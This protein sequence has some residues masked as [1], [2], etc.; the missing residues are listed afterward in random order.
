MS[1]GR[2]LKALQITSP[3][4]Y[5]IINVDLP[6]VGES[7]ILVKIKTV[8]TCSRWDINMFTGHDM[9][10]AHSSPDYPLPPGFPGHEATGYIHAVGS[11]VRGFKVGD[12]VVALEHVPGNGAYAEYMCYKCK[13]LMKL[14]ESISFKQATSFELLKSI[15][16]GMQ[17]FESLLG[18]SILISGL[19]PAGLL[20]MQVAKSWGASNVVGV[21]LSEK[22]L[23][24]ARN[25]QIGEVCHLE[26]LGERQFEMGFDCDG[27]ALSVQNVLDHVSDHSIVFGISAGDVVYRGEWWGKGRRL[28]TYNIRPFNQRDCDLM[29]DLVV[30][31]GLN[32]ECLYTHRIPFSRYTDVIDTLV[33]Q[34]GIKVLF[35]PG[36]DL[37]QSSHLNDAG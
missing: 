24:F 19:G 32:T 8:A 10:D 25:L 20:A 4:N 3:G 7:D 2:P 26:D 29:V 31:K 9:F 5:S 1:G 12:R 30:N 28:E 34:D 36:I 16:I 23:D 35:Y 6:S 14:P 11:R 37:A 33:H 15:V 17:Q 13:D 22:R 27:S 21:D 18:K